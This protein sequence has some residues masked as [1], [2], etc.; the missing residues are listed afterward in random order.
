MNKL[1][2][3][4]KSGSSHINVGDGLNVAS[5]FSKYLANAIPVTDVLPPPTF[6]EL[7]CS[8]QFKKQK[9]MFCP[10][11]LDSRAQKPQ[12]WMTYALTSS[13]LE[14][15]PL[16]KVCDLFNLSLQTSQIP[17]EW[18]AARITPIPKAKA[19]D[20]GSNLTDFRPISVLP[21]ILKGFESLVHSQMYEYLQHHGILYPAQ[22]G[23]RPNHSTQDVLFKD[24]VQLAV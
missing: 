9:R 3:S 5:K 15:Q 16:L 21:I 17:V 1:F 22:S 20:G 12:E 2:G 8:F 13:N 6:Q 7:G 11:C 24:G 10:C 4:G 19:G 18:K 14:P 23:F